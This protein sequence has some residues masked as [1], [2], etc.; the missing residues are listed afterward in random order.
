MPT[1]TTKQKFENKLS[2]PVEV[3]PAPSFPLPYQEFASGKNEDGEEARI[4]LSVNFAAIYVFHKDRIACVKMSDLINQ[5]TP[6]ACQNI[7]TV[8]GAEAAAKAGA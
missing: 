6:A 5:L 4:G 8:I 1:P 7:Q 2:L 3:F